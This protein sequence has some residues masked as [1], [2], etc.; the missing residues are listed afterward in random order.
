MDYD[1]EHE[2]V[3]GD[4]FLKM[5]ASLKVYFAHDDWLDEGRLTRK[6]SRYCGGSKWAFRYCIVSR[7]F[8]MP[9]FFFFCAI[10]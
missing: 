6:R 10:E 2:E 9:V 5:A 3:L 8:T 4:S 7:T 1:L